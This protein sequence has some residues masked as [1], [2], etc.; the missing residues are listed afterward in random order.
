MKRNAAVPT[1]LPLDADPKYR[2]AADLLNALRRK[3][4]ELVDRLTLA[5]LEGPDHRS[6]VVDRGGHGTSVT[7]SDPAIE[8]RRE[9]LRARLAEQSPAAA[10]EP[11]DGVPPAVRRAMPLLRG[12]AVPAR[13]LAAQIAQWTK[14]LEI[15]NAAAAAQEEIVDEIRSECGFRAATALR[16]QHRK[17]LRT[18]Y[19]AARNLAAA[20]EEEH[21]LRIALAK[22]G[23][24]VRSDILPG[25][26]L[27]AL[28]LLGRE[29]DWGS[30]LATFGRRLKDLGIID[31]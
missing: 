5:R 23:H 9:E 26:G 25:P 12:E 27:G 20:A 7:G 16:E 30:Q 10:P 31:G 21:G 1:I 11:D 28:A 15:L 3:A 24:D 18:V 8:R 2:P 17:L 22:C 6:L 13:N 19:E 4:A 14:D 29:S